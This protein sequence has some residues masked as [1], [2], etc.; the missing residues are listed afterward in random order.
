MRWWWVSFGCS[1]D[2]PNVYIVPGDSPAEILVAAIRLGA[3]KGNP[4][5]PAEAVVSQIKIE[6]YPQSFRNKKLTTNEAMEWGSYTK[7]PRELRGNP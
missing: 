6:D 7:R 3:P 4:D 5:K 2:S 1:A